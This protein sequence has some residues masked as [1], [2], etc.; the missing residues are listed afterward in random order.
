MGALVVVSFFV[1]IGYLATIIL[2]FIRE[3]SQKGD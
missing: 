1:L 3:K 2:K